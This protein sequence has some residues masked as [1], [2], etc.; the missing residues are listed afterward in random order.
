MLPSLHIKAI[1]GE[2]ILIDA[3]EGTQLQLY[4]AGI[5]LNRINIILITHMHG[6]HI[7]G[8]PGLLENMSLTGRNKDLLIMGPRGIGDYIAESFKATYFYPRYKLYYAEISGWG[9]YKYGSI[10]IQWF[11]VCHTIETLGYKVLYHKRPKL[12]KEKLREIGLLN[13]PLTGKLFEKGEIT[14]LGRKIKLEDVILEPAR[15]YCIAYTGDTA[16]C[17]RVIEEV[18]GCDLL[19]HEATFASDHKYEAW[20]YGHSTSIDAAIIAKEAEVGKLI[21]YHYSTRY[22]ED[23]SIL[24]EES[25]KIF[26]KT[27]LGKDLTIYEVPFNISESH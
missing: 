13:S 5:S 26:P 3:G 8:L 20:E 24:L 7:F 18:R 15:T 14:Y 12:S 27:E 9:S 16:P 25:K 4:K 23:Y 19:F 10:N 17:T 2:S 6:D 21:L 11:P 1:T 22:K